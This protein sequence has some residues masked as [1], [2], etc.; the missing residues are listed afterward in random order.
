MSGYAEAWRDA[1]R[2]RTAGLPVLP[3]QAQELTRA[4][5]AL[6]AQRSHGAADLAAAFKRT[7]GLDRAIGRSEAGRGVEAMNAAGRA[8]AE[9]K[10]RD[11]ARE[12]G[13][14]PRT[15]DHGME[16]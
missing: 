11:I 2:M 13:L 4:G 8:R 9:G 5:A 12:I 7:P 1:E 15:R 14:P 16:R 3:H 6:D 10:D